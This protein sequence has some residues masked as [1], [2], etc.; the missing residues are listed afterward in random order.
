MPIKSFTAERIA[1][2]GERWP[3][4][5]MRGK[6]AKQVKAH[7]AWGYRKR[8]AEIRERI[9]DAENRLHELEDAAREID[10]LRSDIQD[11]KTKIADYEFTAFEVEEYE[12]DCR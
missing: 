8:K 12:L 11:L 6:S 9:A 7:L 10:Q 5:L 4:G 3:L 2:N 1:P